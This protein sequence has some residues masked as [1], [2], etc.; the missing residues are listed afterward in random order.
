MSAASATANLSA[1]SSTLRVLDRA[2]RHLPEQELA[3]DLLAVNFSPQ[4]MQT[5]RS[6]PGADRNLEAGWVP[7][8]DGESV[9]NGSMALLQM[10][11]AGIKDS[12]LDACILRLRFMYVRRTYAESA[13]K[14][15]GGEQRIGGFVLDE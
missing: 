11:W 8:E 6:L 12:I 15:R 13:W 14:Y 1:K 2:T 9:R 4:T 10:N 5:R 3:V 7:G